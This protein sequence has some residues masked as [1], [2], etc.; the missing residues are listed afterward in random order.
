MKLTG[1]FT[2]YLLALIA[3]L[4]GVWL[5]FIAYVSFGFERAFQAPWTLPKFP[6]N[7]VFLLAGILFLWITYLVS[8]RRRWA[9]VLAGSALSG[10]IIWLLYDFFS[11]EPS[12]WNGLLCLIPFIVGLGLSMMSSTESSA[13]PTE[14]LA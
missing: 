10:T 3:L 13:Q 6:K 14:K 5:V 4:H 7:V 8:R 11:S 2:R 1:K 9:R 12:Q